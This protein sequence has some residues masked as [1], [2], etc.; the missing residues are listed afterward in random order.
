MQKEDDDD[1]DDDDGLVTPARPG[2]DRP[3][4]GVKTCIGGAKKETPSEVTKTRHRL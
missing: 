1:D 2:P 4:R 3:T